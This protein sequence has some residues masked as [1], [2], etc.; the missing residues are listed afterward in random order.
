MRAA[1][2]RAAGGATV[3]LAG[4]KC[5]G[6]APLPCDI[7]RLSMWLERRVKRYLQVDPFSLK[8]SLPLIDRRVGNI[9]TTERRAVWLVAVAG[10]LTWDEGAGREMQPKVEIHKY[11]RPRPQ[12]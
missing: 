3:G 9:Q 12:K 1:S 5:T 10:P 4:S 2:G 8:P 11:R 6:G 7:E